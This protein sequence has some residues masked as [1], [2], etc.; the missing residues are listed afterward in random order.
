[1]SAFLRIVLLLVLMCPVAVNAQNIK[2]DTDVLQD[3]PVLH[4]GR[5][6]PLDSF[7]R[8]SL[9][10]ISGHT[11]IGKLSALDWLTLTMFDP[12]NAALI[13]VIQIENGHV[14]HKMQLVDDKILF[15][16][17]ALNDGIQKTQSDVITLLEKPA[18]D[19][20]ADEKA[21]INT[22]EKVATLI[23][24]M[25]SFSGTLPLNIELPKEYAAQVPAQPSFMDLM[26]IELDLQQDV[27]AL[28]SQKGAD[29]Q[30]FTP[31][32]DAMARTGFNL[33]TLRAGGES[34]NLLRIIPV[35]WDGEQEKW[36][37]PWNAILQEDT[38]PASEF[39]LAL[40]TDLAQSYRNNDAE[41]W[42][43][44]STDIVA[45]TTAQAQESIP[46]QRF[47]VERIYRDVQPYLWITL[48]YAAITIISALA[49]FNTKFASFQKPVIALTALTV[50]IHSGALAARMLILDR[51]P[52]GTL[53]ESVLYVSAI[54]AIAGLIMHFA[55]RTPLALSAGAFSALLLLLSASMF[56]PA[57]DNLEVLV[58]VLNTSFWLTTHVLVITA[59]YAMCIIAAVLAHIALALG[60]NHTAMR[61]TLQ[62]NI[63]LI[64]LV[65]LLFTAVGT[66]LGGIW[67]DQSWGRFWGWDPKENGALLIV[68]WLI[69]VQHGRVSNRFKPASFL[70]A[71][72]FLNV[73]VAVSWFG[74]NLLNVG[75]HSY[76]F[77]SGMAES[78]IAFCALECLLIGGLYWR[79]THQKGAA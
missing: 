37:S 42:Q 24:L 41:L 61:M 58:A 77:T 22:H 34:N 10:K 67:A 13:D 27:K 14:R 11:E 25:R 75:L 19:L 38:T 79:H 57:G 23:M 44:I 21:L 16:L 73:V 59:G 36:A 65:A 5:L 43:Q 46:A 8:L 45:E 56:E 50:L 63:Y 32:E 6:K 17:A 70:A 30:N 31:A 68:L 71:I 20:T 55:K 64:S 48:L 39:L 3:I 78:L 76:G 33:Q 4:E 12:Q 28:V 1:M 60:K 69:W 2:P 9:Q 49:A 40:W 47:I 74:V 51:P 35:T 29:P 54:A 53:Y 18:D 26:Q 62:N 72:A 66:V 52:V 15:N 7:A